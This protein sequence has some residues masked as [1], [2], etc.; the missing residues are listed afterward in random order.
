MQREEK[1]K[2]TDAVIE[3][4]IINFLKQPDKMSEDSFN[5]RQIPAAI[6]GIV[7]G[8]LSLIFFE[9]I[10]WGLLLLLVY[11]AAALA[12]NYLRF[13]FQAKRVK[14]CDYE[15]KTETLSHVCYETYHITR[16]AKRRRGETVHIHTLHF[17]NGKSWSIPENNYSWSV[18]RQ[19]SAFSVY[20]STQSG[21]TFIVVTKKSTGKVFVAYNT[22]FFEYKN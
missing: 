16:G 22:K 18:E 13:K 12:F 7:I 4:D 20:E 8:V 11:I 21:D 1:E 19:M 6:I 9:Y 17:E 2:L 10:I 3:K 15:I 5:K 14:I